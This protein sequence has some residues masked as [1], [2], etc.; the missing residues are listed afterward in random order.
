MLIRLSLPQVGSLPILTLNGGDRTD[1]MPLLDKE[2][3]ESAI[4]RAPIL[5]INVDCGEE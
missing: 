1:F 4:E 3:Q 5:N 2:A